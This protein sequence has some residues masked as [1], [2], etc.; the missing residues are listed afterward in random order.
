MKSKENG[1]ELRK[2]H[3][4][5]G[6]DPAIFTRASIVHTSGSTASL[7][8]KDQVITKTSNYVPLAKRTN[9][10]IT[11]NGLGT[12]DLFQYETVTG[13]QLAAIRGS[14]PQ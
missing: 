6:T 11:Y 4:M 7:A 1:L 12:E 5:F 8:T 3:F 13:T 2:S 14:N 9:I 10:E